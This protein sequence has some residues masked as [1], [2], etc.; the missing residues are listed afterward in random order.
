MNITNED[1]DGDFIPIFLDVIYSSR[2]EKLV[3]LGREIVATHD[4]G[5]QSFYAQ[6]YRNLIDKLRELVK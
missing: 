3:S 1:A 5:G 6:S 2:E 4:S